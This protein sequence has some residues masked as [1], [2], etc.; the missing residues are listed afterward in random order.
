M[1]K[2]ILTIALANALKLD[3]SK[4]YNKSKDDDNCGCHRKNKDKDE[5]TCKHFDDHIDEKQILKIAS[6]DD[7]FPDY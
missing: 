5:W 4:R 3:N 7:D 2:L 6:C 1:S